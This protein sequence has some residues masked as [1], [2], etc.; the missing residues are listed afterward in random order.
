MKKSLTLSLI[1]SL[2]VAFLMLTFFACKKSS[3]G[4]N[5][6][7]TGKWVKTYFQNMEQ[8]QF[9]SDH[10]VEFD[11]L[12]TDS[13]TKVVIG[14]RYKSVGKYTIKNDS[15]IMFDLSNYSNSKNSFGPVTDLTPTSG[16]A[17]VSY[18][19]SLNDQK[20]TLSLY[21]TCPINADCIPSPIVYNRVILGS[22]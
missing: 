9:N 21:F 5:A 13:V 8:Y 20:N 19:F 10:T 16:S 14:Y 12:Q 6:D 11:A 7:I 4:V 22:L 18:A 2:L 15:L 3:T 17:T 1:F